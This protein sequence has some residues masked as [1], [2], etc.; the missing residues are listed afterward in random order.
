MKIAEINGAKYSREDF[1]DYKLRVKVQFITDEGVFTIDIFTTETDKV[2]VRSAILESITSKVSSFDTIHWSTKE[3]DDL[4][5]KF[6]EEI[7]LDN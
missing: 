7:L 6:I 5:S 2:K 4:A 3:Q 1:E